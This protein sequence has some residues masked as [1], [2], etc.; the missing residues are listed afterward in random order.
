MPERLQYHFEPQKGWMNDPNG[1]IFF[2]GRYHAFFQHFPHAPVW[3]PMHWGHAVSDDLIFWEE[4]P[5]ALYPDMPY[6]EGGGCWSGS[7]VVKDDKLYLFYT[8]VS[9]ELGQTQSMA[10]SEDGISFT[11]YEH[12]PVIAQHPDD[13]GFDFRDPKVVKIGDIYYMV[14]GSGKG[15]VGKILL[16]R[17]PDLYA[18]RYVGVLFESADYGKVFEC[19]D[20]FPLGEKYMLMFSQMGVKTHS[21]VM[22]YGD[23]DGSEFTPLSVHRPE[24]GPQFYAPQTLLDDKG[25]RIMIGWLYNWGKKPDEGA[26]YAGALTIPREIKMTDGRLT[27]FPVAEAVPLLRDTDGHVTVENNTVTVF[28]G[29]DVLFTD[30]YD[31]VSDVRFLSDTKTVEGFINGGEAS[32]SVWFNK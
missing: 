31:A 14:C 12:N 26:D 19:P 21:T 10:V 24:A 4:L 16:Y 8:S 7:A 28:R 13:G 29:D 11:K 17:S 23:F 20:F 5:I 6:E 15:G 18:W 1:L 30:T 9:E 25:R 3:G 22:L 2:R 32:F 27:V